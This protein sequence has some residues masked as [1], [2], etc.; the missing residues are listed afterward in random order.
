MLANSS[1]RFRIVKRRTAGKVVVAVKTTRRS[2]L[3]QR[4]RGDLQVLP[5]DCL[6][7]AFLFVDR[8]PVLGLQAT[9]LD[10]P[11]LNGMLFAMRHRRPRLRR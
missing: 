8:A 4:I 5:T 1:A 6:D 10:L 7:E 3:D 9:S 2:L 11:A